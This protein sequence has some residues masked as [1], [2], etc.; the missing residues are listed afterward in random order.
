MDV[1]GNT[2]KDKINTA[3][4]TLVDNVY[5]KLGYVKEFLNS[6]EDIKSILKNNTEQQSIEEFK[7]DTNELAENE[8]FH[9]LNSKMICLSR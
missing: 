8:I 3:F 6:D 7:R 5:T 4:K 2:V 9:L 1:K